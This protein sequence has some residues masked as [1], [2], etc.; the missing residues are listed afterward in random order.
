MNIAKQ[1]INSWKY[2]NLTP[3]GNKTVL[4]TLVTSK[5]NDLYDLVITLPIF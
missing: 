1:V 4:K 5:F 2:R 3:F